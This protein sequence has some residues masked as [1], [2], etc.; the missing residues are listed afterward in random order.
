MY[1]TYVYLV[2]DLIGQTFVQK[3]T[4]KTVDKFNE[5]KLQIEK[6]YA[7]LKGVDA[8]IEITYP[9]FLEKI[10]LSYDTLRRADKHDFTSDFLTAKMEFNSLL[11]DL[12]TY[13]NTNSLWQEMK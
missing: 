9:N 13:G 12:I 2:R 4:Q 5:H 6:I 8:N 1:L 11:H 3:D 10:S 7:Y